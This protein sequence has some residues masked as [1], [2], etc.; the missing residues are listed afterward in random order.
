MTLQDGQLGIRIEPAIFA[1]NTQVFIGAEQAAGVIEQLADRDDP[2]VG[3]TGNPSRDGIG[4]GQAAFLGKLQDDGGGGLL[5]GAGPIEQRSGIAALHRPGAPARYGDR[6]GHRMRPGGG[7]GLVECARQAPGGGRVEL[8]L[9]TAGRLQGSQINRG[10]A[11]RTGI[12]L[13]G[14]AGHG[15][16]VR[17]AGR[18]GRKHDDQQRQAEASCH[19]PTQAGLSRGVQVG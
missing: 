17:R 2:A 15:R 9:Q 5:A 16:V 8:T 19:W 7:K 18:S 4:Q 14:R 12:G 6:D 10:V 3:H 1:M 11:R 13:G